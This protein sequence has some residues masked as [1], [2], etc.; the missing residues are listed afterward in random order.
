M[1]TRLYHWLHRAWYEDAGGYWLLLPISG[2]YWVVVHLRRLLYHIGFFRQAR[3]AVPVIVVGNLTA[4]GTG[5]TPVCIWLAQRL[6]E[7]G[8][9]PGIV[10]RGYGGNRSGQ[11]RV[12]DASSDPVEVGDEPVLLAKRGKCPVIVDAN[13]VRAAEVL[14]A[15]GC[16]LV[17]ADDGLQHLR[18]GRDYEICVVDGARGFG[19]RLLLPAGPLRDSL[20]L[21]ASYDRL[22][23]NGAPQQIAMPD[24]VPAPIVFELRAQTCH[25]L[26]GSQSRS[27]CD[28]A[29]QTVHAVA[30]IGN[31]ARFFALLRSCGIQCIEH[32]LE[33]HATLDA[34][35]LVFDD[36]YA[37]LMTEKDAVKLG[38]KLS[39]RYWYV[40]VEL[41]MDGALA[42]TWLDSIE[43]KLGLKRTVK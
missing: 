9:R 16:D 18:L 6:K 21:L 28:F 8:F 11:P 34:G 13:R 3:I 42:E 23:V 41:E 43:S 29:G 39:N 30:A 26:N 33:D 40:P 38:S 32:G 1:R 27:L 2:L 36:D 22:L 25:R 17:L 14:V 37:I 4:G 19:N 5:K 20:R 35:Q 24:T 12:V 15:T 7:R 31:P 10:S